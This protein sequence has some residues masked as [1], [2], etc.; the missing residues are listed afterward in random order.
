MEHADGS[1]RSAWRR[2]LP[3]KAIRLTLSDLPTIDAALNSASAV[4]LVV[5]YLSIRRKKILA[6]KSCMIAAFICS[7]VFLSCYIWYHAH[8]GVTRFIGTGAVRP[9]YFT[10]LGTHTI[11]AAAIVPLVLITLYFA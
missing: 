4:L 3:G 7:C 1:L 9:F 6:H 11:L 2:A 10:L 5:G 8:H